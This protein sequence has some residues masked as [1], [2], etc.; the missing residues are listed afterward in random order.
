MVPNLFVVPLAFSKHEGF[1]VG[2][3]IAWGASTLVNR[4][5]SLQDVALTS[6]LWRF[7][8]G[9]I[10]PLTVQE[11]QVDQAPYVFFFFRSF[12]FKGV[13]GVLFF[14]VYFPFLLYIVLYMFLWGGS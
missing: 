13:C 4:H 7:L 11:G 6:A 10:L 3:R 2:A 8:V 1:L 9:P 5:P 12:N 14:M